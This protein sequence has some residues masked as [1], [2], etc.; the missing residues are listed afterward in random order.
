[1]FRLAALGGGEGGQFRFAVL[2]PRPELIIDDAQFRSG[3]TAHAAAAFIVSFDDHEVDN[4]WASDFDQD[5]APAEA[6]ILRRRSA[7][8]AWYEH[9]PV[10]RAQMPGMHGLTMHRR[11][12]YGRLMRMHVL[13]TRSYRSDQPCETPD[14]KNC[15]APGAP[16]VT[17]LGA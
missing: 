7:M 2:H 8:Q 16:D 1:A 17:M 9:M 3:L 5:G 11:L 6:F 4:N 12:D 10:R 13:D 15:R 14:Q